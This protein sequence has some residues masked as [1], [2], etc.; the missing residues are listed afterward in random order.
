MHVHQCILQQNSEFYFACLNDHI[1][2]LTLASLLSIEAPFQTLSVAKLSFIV[3]SDCHQSKV[4]VKHT[5]D[6]RECIQC[7]SNLYSDY[8]CN[9]APKMHM[10]Q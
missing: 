7:L 2:V 1:I 8:F 10:V 3:A 9:K 4:S 6:C 5:V